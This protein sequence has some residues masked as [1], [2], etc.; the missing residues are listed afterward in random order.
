MS[1]HRNRVGSRGTW[2]ALSLALLWGIG[3]GDEGGDSEDAGNGVSETETGG[4]GTGSTGATTESAGGEESGGAS[5]D[6][7]ADTITDTSAGGEESAGDGDGDGDGDGGAR[8]TGGD[9]D[10][11]G[12]GD[13]TTTGGDGDGDGDPTTGGD[14]DGD[15]DPTT[16]G[17]GD[18]DGD[19]DADGECDPDRYNDGI[20]DGADP[21]PGDP[22]LP[23]IAA[24]N[25]VYA[26]TSSTLFTV[27]PGA[28]Y[29]VTQIGAFTFDQNGG[30][31][32]DI[33]VDSFGV[34]YAVTFNDLF[35]CD[36]ATAA[37]NFLASLPQ[38]FNGL[39]LVPPGVIDPVYDTLVGISNVGNWYQL[40]VGNG[41]VVINALGSYGTGYSSSGDAFSIQGVGTYAAVNKTG[42]ADD[43]IVSSDPT[44]G[45]VMSEVATL[46][47]YGSIF[48]LAGWVGSVFAFSS[49]GDIL[50]I[51]PVMGTWSVVQSTPHS[52]WGAG[53]YTVLPQ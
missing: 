44:S 4:E 41:T 1:S 39:T 37:C 29:T 15:G 14:G 3:C 5:A 35:V 20:P 7:G 43:V 28:P 30:S 26:Q 10:G 17:D 50:L 46:T 51:D 6:G 33:A 13:A 49:N 31:V 36:P 47:G 38:S 24:A 16:G 2:I 53:V 45:T 8:T 9:G 12:D 19:G 40:D 25:L 22:D 48:G 18:G 23:G 52:W 11:D 34:L 42:I 27:L 21:F 32:T